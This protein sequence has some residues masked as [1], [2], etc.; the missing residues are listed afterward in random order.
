GEVEALLAAHPAVR[1]AAVVA[2]EAGGGERRLVAYVVPEWGWID[3]AGREGAGSG[4]GWEAEHEG[5][6][7]AA[8][9]Y[10][11]AGGEGEAGA[12]AEAG[13]D[14]RGWNS[15]YTG[16]PIPAEEM[17]EWVEATVER[18]GSL[19]PR[20]VLEIG[21]GT[22]LLLSRLAGECARY[23]GTDISPRA[24]GGVE[25]LRRA[26]AELGHVELLERAAE[27]FSG[28]E[29]GSFD[30]V[31][32]NSVVQYLP[33]LDYLMRVLEGAVR[34]LEPGG[35][36]FVGDVRDLRLL[37]AFRTA[38]ET[39]RAAPG[40]SVG[41]WRE[42]IEQAQSQEVE[43]VVD[44]G[45]FASLGL[46]LGAIR[47]V[48]LLQK[49]GR[50]R[51]ELTGFRYDVVLHVG[52]GGEAA[53]VPA[54]RALDWQAEELTLDALRARLEESPAEV[55]VVH[56]IP[57]ARV[58]AALRQL[59]IRRN[60][61]GVQTVA[62][63]RRRAIEDGVEPED[64]WSLGEALGRSVEV[65]LADCGDAARVD[66]VFASRAGA[67]DR[68]IFASPSRP[69]RGELAGYATDPL[70]GKRARALVRHLRESL[71]E[72]LPEYMVPS[73]FVQLK[74]LPLTPNGKLDRRALPA[75]EG[76]AYARRSYEA[77]QGETETAL[78]EIWSAVLGVEQVGRHD[79]FFEL[80]GHSLLAV[81]V[82]SRVR[83]AL[84]VEVALSEVF[85]RPVLA[86]LARELRATARA[87]L[88]PIGRVER[89]GRLPLSFAQQRLWFLEQMG[90]MGGTYHLRR[91]L[92]FRGE[93]DRAA[94]VRALDRVVAR[95]EALRTVFAVVDGE[96]EQRIAPAEESRFHLLEHD[97]AGQGKA[98]A[99]LRRLAREE[100]LAPFDL[101]RGPLIRGRLVRMAEDDHVLL[102]TMHHVVSDGWSMGVLTRELGV[103]YGAFRRGGADPLPE[104]E[105][106]Y[107]DYAAW[108][109]RWVEG[110]VLAAQ[111]E[112]WRRTLAG[113]PEL[114][115]L[116][117]DRPRPARQD[118]AGAALRV[119]L[120]EELAAGLRA[121]SRR[122]GTTLFMTLLA[123]W[124]VVLSRL[125]GQQ[126]VVVGAPVAN[127]GRR[128]IEGLIGFFVNTLAH[129][130]ELSGSPTTAE[131][132]GRVKQRAVEAQAH[133]DIPFEQVVELVQP[134]RS[135]AH[136]PLF[137]VMLAWQNAP[138][139]ELRLPGLELAR[140]PGG[141][142]Q[143]TA[144]FDLS[145]SLQE[146]GGRIVGGVTYATSLFDRATVERHAAYLR[147]ALQAMTAREDRPVER[148]ELMPEAERAQVLERWNATAAEYPRELCLHEIFA[149]QAGRT[150]DAVALVFED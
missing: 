112:Y 28:F 52:E 60:P 121:L 140:A 64:L 47:H 79:H 77:P 19:G 45:F 131:L 108:Q 62:E 26:R 37:G 117:T 129:R 122:Q 150:P 22:G 74:E 92:R 10:A 130:V 4:A 30:T 136:T 13:F 81:Q 91:Q 114:L 70:R 148:L 82:I 40:L 34:V 71:A 95:H 110:E 87:E 75:P 69:E 6:W 9:D 61:Q 15:S 46:E 51:N 124:A 138:R 57:N 14:I 73:A 58:S 133:Q 7:K 100:A 39:Y 59:E 80:G 55:V 11:Y 88:P 146:A 83:Q 42:R 50:F 66:A 94:L 25:A 21:C 118:H 35:R 53:E 149:R 84:G 33:G 143:T 78:A 44:P 97:L 96:P 86:E 141:T 72:R 32:I 5:G 76:E 23:V 8:W 1:E 135:L 54:G 111:A 106:Q 24:L 48:E 120:D 105:V 63:V 27:D 107:A 139:G 20:R 17:R 98:A 145:L 18:I 56:G 123:G 31:V 127:R 29:A 36:V 103:L 16:E 68:R 99:E 113:A 142:K 126:D 119:E 12:P 49:R 3:A 144:K 67:G 89:G 38:V 104:L 109:R 90:R 101:E 134:A 125:S 2:R 116:P 115:E 147:R 132:L 102:L 85:A 137:Q 65:R 128:E 93:L 43:L 41:E